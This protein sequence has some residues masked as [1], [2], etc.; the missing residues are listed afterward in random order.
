[1]DSIVAGIGKAHKTSLLH[2][3]FIPPSLD[4][5]PNLYVFIFRW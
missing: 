5:H 4:A 1:M 3:P 2:V